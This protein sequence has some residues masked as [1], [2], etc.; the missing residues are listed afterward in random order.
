[1][2]RAG[3]PF[4]GRGKVARHVRGPAAWSRK[5]PAR[6]GEPDHSRTGAAVKRPISIMNTNS[7]E[8]ES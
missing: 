1:M 6:L 8:N 4:P 7:E 3:E 2:K 5:L